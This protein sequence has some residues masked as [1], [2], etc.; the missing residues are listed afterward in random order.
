MGR[1]VCKYRLSLYGAEMAFLTAERHNNKGM[2]NKQELHNA[3]NQIADTQ[4][5]LFRLD[6]AIGLIKSLKLD[7]RVKEIDYTCIS[8]ALELLTVEKEKIRIHSLINKLANE[9]V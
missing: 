3:L 8:E 5:A 6:T 2:T 1:I 7:T 9:V 4:T